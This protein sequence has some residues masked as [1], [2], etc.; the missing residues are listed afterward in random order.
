MAAEP[1]PRPRPW[2]R[3]RWLDVV[4]AA[5]LVAFMLQAVDRFVNGTPA[6]PT[7]AALSAGLATGAAIGPRALEWANRSRSGSAS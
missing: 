1:K 2:Y 3:L 6:D 7:L 5:G 4:A